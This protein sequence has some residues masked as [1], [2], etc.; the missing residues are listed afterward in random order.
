[1]WIENI[2]A[3]DVIKGFHRPT[4][5]NTIL[6]QILD[7]DWVPEPQHRFQGRHLFVFLDLEDGDDHVEEMGITQ[8]QAADIVTLLKSA[9]E[10]EQNVVVHCTAGM[11]RSGAV[12]EVGVMLGFEDS[13]RAR[14]PN[15][16]VKTAL[17][18]ELGWTYDSGSLD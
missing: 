14:T 13:G 5:D 12:A 3:I 4:G 16:R 7:G 2:A 18:R 1:M 17:M 9:L 15:L 6:I 10:R 11:C 8:S